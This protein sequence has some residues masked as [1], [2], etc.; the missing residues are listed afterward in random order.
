MVRCIRKRR[1]SKR[2]HL[3]GNLKAKSLGVALGAE[4]CD[5]AIAVDPVVGICLA[6]KPGD[7][8]LLV[9]GVISQ[10]FPFVV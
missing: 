9:V 7:L 6:G 10:D 5:L 4:P 8:T 1:R 3:K 2:R